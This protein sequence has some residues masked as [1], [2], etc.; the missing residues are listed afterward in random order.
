[1]RTSIFSV[2]VLLW[3]VFAISACHTKRTKSNGDIDIE[4]VQGT[5]CVGYTYWWAESGPFIGSCGDEL[6]LA[7]T[8]T[9]VEITNPTD[10]PGPLYTAQKGIVSIENIFK[11][12]ELRTNTY[13]NQKFI[14]TDCF[15]GLGLNVGDKVLIFCYDYEDDYIIAGG[16]SILKIDDFNVPVVKSIKTYISGDQNPIPLKKDKAIWTAYGLE[17]S[18]EKIITCAEEMEALKNKNKTSE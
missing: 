7:F 18:L 6:A 16:K 17:K 5:L 3:A 1:M 8:G 14:S 4:F 15:Y 11:I 9:I 10:E 13:A 2:L 12:K